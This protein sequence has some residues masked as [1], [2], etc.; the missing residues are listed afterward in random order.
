MERADQ[1]ETWRD[2]E[3]D[4]DRLEPGPVEH[5]EDDRT[6]DQGSAEIRLIEH[7]QTWDQDDQRRHDKRANP[8]EVDVA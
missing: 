7:E 6:K 3:K 1:A 4:G 2:D 5:R 8:D